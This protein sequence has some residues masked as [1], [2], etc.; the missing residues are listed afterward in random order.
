MACNPRHFRKD[1]VTLKPSIFGKKDVEQR[2]LSLIRRQH[3]SQQDMFEI[4][5]AI[6][7]T[8]EGNSAPGYVVCEAKAMRSIATSDGRRAVC[9][10]DD[11]TEAT[12]DL[13]ANQAHAVAVASNVFDDAELVRIRTELAEQFGELVKF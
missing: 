10:F 9:L 2:G 7:K 8:I 6:A 3:L 13:P 1:G 12:E 4:S 5:Q 11:P